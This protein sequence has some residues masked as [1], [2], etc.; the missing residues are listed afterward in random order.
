MRVFIYA[1][2]F[3]PMVGGAETLVMLL[4]RGL[5]EQLQKGMHGHNGAV[6]QYDKR[7][8]TV[9]TPTPAN[10]FDDSILPFR[11]VRQPSLWQLVRLLWNADIVHL[12]GPCFLPLILGLILRKPTIVE[13]HGFQTVCPNGQLFFE[14][15]QMPCPGHFMAR[16]H[17]KCLRCNAN[18]GKLYSLGMWLLTFLRRR[19]CHWVSVNV[20]LT[21]WLDTVLKLPRTTTIYCGVP[22]NAGSINL[23]IPG[24]RLTLAFMGRLVSLKGVHTLLQAAHRLRAG[25]LDFHIKII[26][27]GP[28]RANLESQVKALGLNDYVTF[29]G[30]LNQQELDQA[31]ADVAVIVMPSLAGET[32]GLVAAENMMCG[33]LM[34]VSNDG[35]LSEVVGDTRLKFQPGDS[36]GLAGCLQ[37]VLEN[38]KLM[39]ELRVEARKRALQFFR[40][41]RMVEDHLSLYGGI[42]ICKD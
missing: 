31:L 27:R 7:M 15:T 1:H 26:G 9:A 13:H 42:L 34:V 25:G 12:A 10:G 29:M 32:F 35:A 28:E 18:Q 20:V 16:S 38:P 24:S 37:M 21:N 33:R 5:V 2:A 19:L 22:D 41:E 40:Q 17:Y 23:Q 11:V 6:G 14:P 4:A 36:E 30:Y 3:A 8:V 39:T